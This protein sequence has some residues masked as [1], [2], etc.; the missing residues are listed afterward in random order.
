MQFK[1]EWLMNT[2]L[3]MPLVIMLVAGVCIATQAPINAQLGRFSGDTMSAAMLS[4]AVGLVVL[5]ILVSVRGAMPT[6]S[7]L[8][9]APWWVWIGGALGAFYVWGATF[10]V[11]KIGVVATISALILGQLVGG[12]IIDAAGAFDVPVKSIDLRRVA[13]VAFVGVGVFLSVT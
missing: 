8:K 1:G 7:A 5:V 12:A 3:M 10:S 13:A 2:G 11:Q 6:P 4:F 9:A